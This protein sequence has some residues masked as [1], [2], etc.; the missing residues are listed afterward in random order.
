MTRIDLKT[1]A[2]IANDVARKENE[3]LQVVGVSPGEGDGNYTEI[4]MVVN[5]CRSEPCKISLGVFRDV[6]ETAL[7]AQITDK[8]HEHL[9]SAH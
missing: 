7:R 8:L 1:V 2:N 5:G 4:M 9:V 6:S 3:K